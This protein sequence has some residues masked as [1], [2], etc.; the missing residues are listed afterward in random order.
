MD[1]ELI[2][3]IARARLVTVLWLHDHKRRQ[4]IGARGRS[5]RTGMLCDHE[6]VVQ[7]KARYESCAARR[8]SEA[9]ERAEAERC[10]SPVS[11]TWA[12]APMPYIADPC[13]SAIAE[14]SSFRGRGLS[15]RCSV[16]GPDKQYFSLPLSLFD[17]LALRARSALRAPGFVPVCSAWRHARAEQLAARY[18]SAQAS[19]TFRAGW[20]TRLRA[21]VR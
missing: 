16:P 11:K 17:V 7:R 12:R 18:G 4:S 15:G 6:S 1:V 8:E 19:R 3:E 9:S 20:A 13:T 21:C 5:A 14:C 2:T 10:L